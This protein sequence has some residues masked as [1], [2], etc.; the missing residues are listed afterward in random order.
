[1]R[2]RKVDAY[3]EQRFGKPNFKKSFRRGNIILTP[4]GDKYRLWRVDPLPHSRQ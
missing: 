4:M 3:M 1:M 2:N